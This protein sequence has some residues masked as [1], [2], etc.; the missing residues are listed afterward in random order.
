MSLYK[1]KELIKELFD[2]KKNKGREEAKMIFKDVSVFGSVDLINGVIKQKAPDLTEEKELSNYPEKKY[3]VFTD[4]NGVL[5]NE[6]MHVK[7]S[8]QSAKQ[9][10]NFVANLRE[11]GMHGTAVADISKMRF[12]IIIRI[13][14][15]FFK[16]W[17]EMV[18]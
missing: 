17:E 14:K 5:L 18:D 15:K 3:F 12:P 2:T 6:L 9:L 1:N 7:T 8:M 13:Y 11:S 16:D 4:D 10:C